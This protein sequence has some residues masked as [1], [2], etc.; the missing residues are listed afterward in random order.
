MLNKEFNLAQYKN[1]QKNIIRNIIDTAYI[2]GSS[3]AHIGGALS[4][5]D[6]VTVL[7][8][9]IININKENF[10]NKSRDYFILSKGHACLTYY[11]ILEQKGFIT[12]KDLNTFEKDGSNL[13]GHPVMNSNM[14]ID[15]STGSLGIGIGLGVG[16]AIGLKKLGSKNQIFVIIGDGECNEGS[17][18][19]AIMSAAHFKLD[20]FNLIVDRNKL[21]QTGSSSDI[22]NLEPLVEKIRSF[23]FNTHEVDGHNPEELYAK[24]IMKNENMPKALVANTIKGKYLSF[25]EG[26]NK[27]HH[28]ILTKKL[29]DDALK[30]LNEI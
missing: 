18:W 28:A 1:I 13:L 21:Q 23:G 3:S 24:L 27:F 7:F 30:E 15:F 29:Y 8:E 16:L 6:I 14:G 12:K 22:M 20:N 2:A 25:A 5:V 17:V 19:E 11:S 9:H 4:I 26:N 10:K